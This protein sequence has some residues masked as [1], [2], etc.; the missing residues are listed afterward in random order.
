METE[1]APSVVAENFLSMIDNSSS[2]SRSMQQEDE[3]HDNS[4]GKLHQLLDS[5]P[6][7]DAVA[8]S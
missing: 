8:A 5:N 6:R 7:T 4:I 3:A 2:I 1:G